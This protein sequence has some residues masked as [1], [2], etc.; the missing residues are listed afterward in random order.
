M[1]DD[2]FNDEEEELKPFD[3]GG[4]ESLSG[5]EIDDLIANLGAG[6]GDDD[7]SGEEEALEESSE[8]AEVAEVLDQ[9]DIDAL[10]TETLDSKNDLIYRYDGT[11]YPQ[12]HKVAVEDY[13]FSNPVFM[14]EGEMRKVRIRHEKFIHLLAA[15]L[16][17]F[18]RM[19]FGLKMSKLYTTQYKRYTESI[20]NPTHI[21]LFKLQQFGG[22]GIVDMNSR[23][24]MTIID[25]MLGGGGHSIRDE[26]YL[27]EMET[28]LIEDVVTVI[29]DEWCNQWDD[30]FEINASIV[31]HENNG[32]FL[33][34]SAH[35]AI[36]LVISMEATLGDCSESIQLG[37]PY[38]TI[39]PVIKKMQEEEAKFD[40]NS[41]QKK[42]NHWWASYE[43]I[44][45]EVTAEWNAFD[46]KVSELIQ[47]RKGDVL[48]LA[49]DLLNQTSVR[50][51]NATHFLG[52]AGIKEGKVCVQINDRCKENTF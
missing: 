23:L 27:T 33:Q 43:Q 29:L 49:P 39:E 22:V 45:V 24:A 41:N 52:T 25:R 50:F 7:D 10:M 51:K 31:G 32:R 42:E 18:L 17:M 40:P 12:D 4:D 37:I 48:M 14:T 28:A 26:R 19:D 46:C 5:N 1:A 34:V 38:Y 11:L 9:S 15:R 44:G 35:D 36:M 47:L 16:S 21:S 30:M 8:G 13:D 2:D 3:G 6:G 20:Q